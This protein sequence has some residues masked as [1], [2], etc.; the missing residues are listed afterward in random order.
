MTSPYVW[1]ALRRSDAVLV[2]SGFGVFEVRRRAPRV[3]VS[4]Q[5]DSDVVDGERDVMDAVAVL[6][7]VLRDLAVGRQRRR[8]HERDVVAPHHVAGPIP[9]AGLQA[10]ER[11][12]REAPQR[13]VVRRRLAGIADPELDVVDALERQEVLR[14]GVGV[15]VRAGRR[16]GWRRRAGNGVGHAV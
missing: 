5:A 10:G 11:D 15:L 6:A 14:L 12:R 8:D 13:A 3:V 9:D 4:R 2:G 7:D 1:T 16:P